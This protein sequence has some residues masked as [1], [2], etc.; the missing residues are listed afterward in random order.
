MALPLIKVPNPPSSALENKIA[1]PI[2]QAYYSHFLLRH[3]FFLD[4]LQ[5]MAKKGETY[6]VF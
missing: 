2:T 1:S 3:M 5:L 6:L 4:A